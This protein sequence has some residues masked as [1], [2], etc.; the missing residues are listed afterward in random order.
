VI[1]LATTTFDKNIV[2]EQDAAKRL[3]KILDKPVPPRPEIGK[4]FWEENERKLEKWLSH[5]EK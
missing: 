4:Q 5:S 1:H 2:L 3:V